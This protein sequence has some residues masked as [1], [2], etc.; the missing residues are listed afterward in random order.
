[1]IGGARV[2]R[3]WEERVNYFLANGIGQPAVYPRCG[4]L[5]EGERGIF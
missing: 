4:G 2:L 1:M 3:E 5:G